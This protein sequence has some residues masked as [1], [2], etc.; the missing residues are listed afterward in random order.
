[1]S[2]HLLVIMALVSFLTRS[3]STWLPDAALKDKW[4]STVKSATMCSFDVRDASSMSS[5][6]F[7]KEYYG[8]RPVKLTGFATS[9]TIRERLRRDR[10]LADFGDQILV[11]QSSLDDG[12]KYHIAGRGKHIEPLRATLK[13]M[14]SSVPT[15]SLP[16]I[17]SQERQTAPRPGSEKSNFIWNHQGFVSLLEEWARHVPPAL[18]PTF[19]HA[20]HSSRHIVAS[21]PAHAWLLSVGP[22]GHSLNWHQ[23]ADSLLHLVHGVKYWS[24]YPSNATLPGSHEQIAGK[25]LYMEWNETWGAEFFA[26]GG[27]TLLERCV[28]EP[29]EAMYT[30]EGWYHAVVNLGEAIGVG[31]QHLSHHKKFAKAWYKA[32]HA[33]QDARSSPQPK[34]FGRA[35]G[36]LAPIVKKFPDFEPALS[37]AGIMHHFMWM[38]GQE[39]DH[40]FKAKVALQRSIE[41]DPIDLDAY[42]HLGAVLRDE[43]GADIEQLR[44][45]VRML[46]KAV[47]LGRRTSQEGFAVSSLARAEDMLE[48]QEDMLQE[49]DMLQD[50]LQG[51]L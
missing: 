42:F 11:E 45:A 14:R 28:Q 24:L 50:M 29:G 48:G 7:H 34:L 46:R 25:T 49:Q 43:P 26:A 27:G 31:M 33:Y 15:R 12:T 38:S 35:L 21:E 1:V 3:Q 6:E 17:F 9:S 13:N 18:H 37:R 5:E 22:S 36:L 44:E 4:A 2:Q 32:R 51:E 20:H 23:H 30:P 10:F 40:L 39:Q 41:L 19:G 16:F 47:E 8:R